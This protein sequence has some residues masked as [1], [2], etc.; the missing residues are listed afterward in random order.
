MNEKTFYPLTD[1]ICFKY[2]FS[3]KEMLSD[4]LNSFYEFVGENKKVV[5]I[6]ITTQKEIIGKKRKSKTFYGD[7]L[8]YLDCDEIVSIEMYTKFNKREYKKSL[9]YLT[10]VYSE[11]FEEGDDYAQAKKVIGISLMEG[12]YHLNNFEIVNDYGF[13]NKINYGK[14]EDEYLQ[15]YLVRLDKVKGIVYTDNKK[16]FIKWLRF[17]KAG[18][19]AEMEKIAKGDKNMEQA[20]KFMKRF[21]ND[22]KNL[23]IFDSI[24]D[25]ERN[26]REDGILEGRNEEHQKLLQT[27]KN[28]FDMGMP[29][30]KIAKATGLSNEEI[31]EL[32]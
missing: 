20:L 7:I 32:K 8:A 4:F 15:M 17:I 24:K 23:S 1:D 27:A 12:N 5:A 19:L 2:L 3:K 14:T 11:Q 16:R 31:E 13:V 9:A 28:L 26:A 10:R 30:S 29:I 21:V 6:E 18:D 25:R 22:E